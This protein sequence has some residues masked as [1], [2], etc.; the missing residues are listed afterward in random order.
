METE[1]ANRIGKILELLMDEGAATRN[2]HMRGIHLRRDE[3][4]QQKMHVK[5]YVTNKA[6]QTKTS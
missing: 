3:W 4:T 5:L 6:T 2:L 1:N